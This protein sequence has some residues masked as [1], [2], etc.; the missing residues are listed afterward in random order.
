VS[1]QRVPS[2]KASRPAPPTTRRRLQTFFR[3][4]KGTVLLVLLGLAIIGSFSYHHGA[5]RELAVAVPA[6]AAVD[7]AAT[8]WRTGRWI[9]PSGAIISGLL[10]GMVLARESGPA[11]VALVAALAA[12]SKHLLRTNW[13]NVFNPAALA[14]I[15]TAPVF[16]TAQSWWGSLPYIPVIGFLIVMAAG[17]YVASKVNKVPLALS[18]L[19][20]TL[21]VMTFASFG[22]AAVHTEQVF[23]APDINALVF[24]GAFMLTDPPTSPAKQ[25]DQ[26]W[27][28]AVAGVIAAIVFLATGVQWFILAGLPVAN[29]AESVRRVVVARRRRVAATGRRATA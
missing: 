8:F 25:G 24:F 3:T 9:F 10:V 21:L 12:L 17:W 20:P 27:F 13:S 5:W 22:G 14:L 15:V 2:R 19:L 7:I 18:Y 4:P 6:A 26:V 28:G 11:L 29:A 16:H 23:R 1:A